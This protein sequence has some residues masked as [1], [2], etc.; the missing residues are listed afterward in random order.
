M[1][2]LRCRGLRAPIRPGPDAPCARAADV[3][4][5]RLNQIQV[6]GSHNSYRRRT[7]GP[8]FAHV[9][10]LAACCPE[11]LDP[12]NWDYDHLPLREQL[13]DYGMRALEIDLFND[14]AGGRFYNRQGLRFVK[15]AGGAPTSPELLEPGLKVLH[16]PDFD[17]QTHH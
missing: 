3:D 10:S 14:P 2:V 9:Q 16:V 15:R 1:V 4:G 17:Y 8:L 13:D 12:E 7:Y 11:E 5:L 6:V